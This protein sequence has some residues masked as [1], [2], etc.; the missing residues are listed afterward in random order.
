VEENA[1]REIRPY[2]CTKTNQK[3]FD[4]IIQNGLTDKRLLDVGSG[5]GYFL[6]KLG[7]Y[8]S[9]QGASP[10]EHL[11]ACDLNP[12]FHQYREISCVPF[13]ARQGLPFVDDGFDFV[14][15]IEVIEHLE[16]AYG[17]VHE[18][19]RVTKKG[20]KVFVTTPN[21]LNINSR[22]RAFHSGFA[23]LFNPLP[24][25]EKVPAFCEGHIHPLNLYYL[26]YAFYRA[27][28]C[29]VRIHYDRMKKSG[30]FLTLMFYPLIRLAFAGY[31]ARSKRRMREIFEE[32]QPLLKEINSFAALT[33]RTVIVEGVK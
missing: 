2:S 3:I 19:H 13:D 22:L 27:G 18:L 7:D 33:A 4:F 14:T 9:L 12:S 29:Q 23:L 24:L 32:N 25:R 1:M 10:A 28:F 6:Q 26:G 5:E 30:A 20:G 16:N 11:Y 15:S 8:L 21:L 17:F 31:Q